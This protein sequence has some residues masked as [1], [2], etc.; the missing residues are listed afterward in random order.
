MNYIY[1]VRIREYVKTNEQIYKF[2]RTDQELRF[3][4]Y[5]YPK[6][7]QVILVLTVK[8]CVDFE[9][10][11]IKI[12]KKKFIQ[13]RDLGTEYFEGDPYKMVALISEKALSENDFEI[14]QINDTIPSDFFKSNFFSRYTHAKRWHI[15]CEYMPYCEKCEDGS[16]N[17]IDVETFCSKCVSCTVFR[18]LDKKATI[19]EAKHIY[20]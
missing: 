20:H 8:N 19:E 7:S 4:M 15:D 14:Q 13:R 12:F 1:L 11:M 16:L 17:K 9:T 2:G 5:G 3:R 18:D 6:G 10:S